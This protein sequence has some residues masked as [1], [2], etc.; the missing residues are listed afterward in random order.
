MTSFTAAD[1]IPSINCRFVEASFERFF[2]N[3]EREI[4]HFRNF[5]VVLEEL[6]H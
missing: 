1:E 4:T 2:N 3:L 5:H 6:G